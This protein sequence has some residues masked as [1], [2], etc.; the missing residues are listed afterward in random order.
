MMEVF[1]DNTDVAAN[2]TKQPNTSLQLAQLLQTDAQHW[3][4]LLFT[5]GGKLELT[6]CF[7]YLLYWKFNDDGM[8]TLTSKTEI[9]HKCM[10]Y[11]GNETEP[12]EIEQKD[13]SE[14]HKTLGVMKAPNRS[15]AGEIKNSK[16][17][18]MR[19]R[20]PSLVTMLPTLTPR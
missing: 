14:A 13:C 7:F 10:L 16:R 4:K 12:T 9:S 15:Q 19:M 3:E 18:A 8:P 2:D 11:Q 1:A 17:S 6:K 20:Q 5:S